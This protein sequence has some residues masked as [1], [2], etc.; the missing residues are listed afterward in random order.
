MGFRDISSF[1]IAL[2][3]KQGWRIMTEPNSLLARILKA[4]YFPNCHFL[5]AKQ[6]HRSSYSWQSIIKASWILKRGCIWNIGN[7]HNINIWEDRWLHPQGSNPTW[8]PKPTNTNLQKLKDIINTS[9][10]EWDFQTINQTFFPMEA[11]KILNI[12]ILNPME[13]DQICWQ[14]TTDGNYPVKSG[15]NAQIEWDYSNSNQGQT[16]NNNNEAQIWKKLWNTKAPPKQI[17][18]MWRIL[19]NDIPIKPNLISKGILCDSLCPRCN[20]ATESID[21]AFLHC[22]WVSQ[23]WFSSPLTITTTNIQSQS[24]CDWI[25]YM[26]IHADKDSFQQIVSITYNIWLTRNQKVFKGVNTPVIEALKQALKTLRDYLHHSVDEHQTPSHQSSSHQ[27]AFRNRNDMC[28]SPPP[29]NFLKLNVDAHLRDDGRWGFGMVLQ[30]ED[31]HFVGAAT[32]VLKGS[33]DATLAE[34]MGICEALHWIETLRINHVIIETDAE[35]IVKA[36]EKKKFPRTNWG[37][38]ANRISRDLVNLDHVSVKWVNRKGN[39]AAHDLTRFAFVEPTKTWSNFF[40]L[41][42]LSHIPSDMEGIS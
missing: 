42:I 2:L 33:D 7:G 27:T 15:Y 28:W 18:L 9:N 41:C 34:T 14:G 21:H 23:L 6:G 22:D 26:I 12:P 4:K 3:A 39:K 20:K 40:P 16:S 5:K 38:I 32:K 36:M 31:G 24:Y 8:T 13:E 10:Y 25:K 11:E 29:R 37:T 17:H 19:N 35:G 30:G 1:N